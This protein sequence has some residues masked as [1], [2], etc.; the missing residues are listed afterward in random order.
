MNASP[1]RTSPRSLKCHSVASSSVDRGHCLVSDDAKQVHASPSHYADG[2]QG[3]SPSCCVR[4]QPLHVVHFTSLT[5][6]AEQAEKY[7]S[8]WCPRRTF[9]MLWCAESVHSRLLHESK[10]SRMYMLVG[11][12]DH[13][14]NCANAA[15]AARRVGAEDIRRSISRLALH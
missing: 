4:G 14:K 13:F 5:W 12:R 3:S 15:N 7:Q 8:S 11:L 9:K 2:P 1:S 6:W 10:S